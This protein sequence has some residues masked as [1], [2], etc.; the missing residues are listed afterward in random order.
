MHAGGPGVPPPGILE[1]VI[2]LSNWPDSFNHCA[3][4]KDPVGEGP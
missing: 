2:L 3:H 4:C 1:K